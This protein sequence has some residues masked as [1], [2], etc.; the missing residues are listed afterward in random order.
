[1][2]KYVYEDKA[3]TGMPGKAWKK[4]VAFLGITLCCMLLSVCGRGETEKSTEP[5]PKKEQLSGESVSEEV[6]SASSQSQDTDYSTLGEMRYVNGMLYYK[7]LVQ[8]EVL[9]KTEVETNE[10][11]DAEA[12]AKE[13]KAGSI[14]TDSSNAGE[15]EAGRIHSAIYREQENSKA[16]ELFIIDGENRIYTYQVSNAGELFVV[17]G[18]PKE[19]EFQYQIEKRD[20]DQKLLWNAEIEIPQSMDDQIV[21][22]GLS[23]EGQLLLLTSA[24][25]CIFL[26]ENGEKIGLQ[27][28]R[29]A[30]QGLTIQDF[31]VV[32]I[33]IEGS[34]VYHFEKERLIVQKVD[35]AKCALLEETQVSIPEGETSSVKQNGRWCDVYGAQN[36]LYLAGEKR[37]WFYD[38]KE[39]TVNKLF[40]WA[41]SYVNV[42][43]DFLE[44]AAEEEEGS[45]KLF[46]YDIFSG[47]SSQVKVE[48]KKKTDLAKRQEITLGSFYRQEYPQEEI[49]A[50]NNS[51]DQYRIVEKT[52]KSKEEW[53]Q[54]LLNGE[55]PDIINLDGWTAKELATKGVL[56]DL[57]SYFAESDVV[58]EE[59]LLDAVREGWT[60]DGGIRFV[61]NSFILDGMLVKKGYTKDGGITVKDFFGLA[62]KGADSY[63]MSYFY[64]QQSRE[65]I[66]YWLLPNLLNDFVDW[67][68]WTC[69]FENQ[70]F[71]D[72]LEGLKAVGETGQADN[73]SGEM[74]V[75]DSSSPL[76]LGLKEGHYSAERITVSNVDQ[77]LQLKE[78][79]EGIA[80]L[81]GYPTVDGRPYYRMLCN[82]ELALNSAS[83]QKEGAWKFLEYVLTERNNFD[84]YS[85][86]SVWRSDFEKQITHPEFDLAGVYTNQYSG[87]KTE[88]GHPQMTEE[89]RAQLE[90]IVKNGVWGLYGENKEIVWIVEE[91]SEYFYHG[92]KSAA[93]VAHIIQ[94]R[95]ELMMNE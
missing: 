62:E 95:V 59:D 20:R 55:A 12:D 21:D 34:L 86:F 64:R 28:E 40:D 15:S 89:W 74:T 79:Y 26:D 24:G 53:E 58:K 18:N 39:G 85:E 19:A 50:Y 31:G 66:S 65:E 92:D 71:Y 87:E 77:Y 88:N 48:K 81:S 3:E 5:S 2:Q 82:H 51:Q 91:E 56:E 78:A 35:F 69:N 46:L 6:M 30:E 14:K 57:T 52:Y 1:M 11:V 36:G 17:Y 93:E 63:L 67:E 10:K 4:R 27:E 49:I 83:E 80:D 13:K 41:D 32:N 70:A 42:Q 37:L 68:N 9:E 7:K 90:Q 8:E 43:R 94:S 54:A 75:L 84:S 38:C 25:E 61:Q 76:V 45:V 73:K 47:K 60:I 72:V 23:E 16:E 22:S 44:L 29:Y 33:G